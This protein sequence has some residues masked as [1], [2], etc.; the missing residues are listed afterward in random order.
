MNNWDLYK[1]SHSSDTS[2]DTRFK[3]LVERKITAVD[4]SEITVVG[5][6]A[7][8]GCG[9]LVSVNLPNA[10]SA[11]GYGIS[12]NYQLKS[13]NL[14]LLSSIGNNCFAGCPNLKVL[15]LPSLS[16]IGAS[17]FKS[18]SKLDTLILRVNTVCQLDNINAFEGTPIANGAGYIYVPSALVETYKTATNWTVYAD[19]IRAIEDYPEI[20]GG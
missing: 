1:Y 12:N 4:D 10:I 9:I 8:G 19:Q 11:Q 7:F 18:C 5:S 14:P 16:T 13:V 2:E 15:D 17:A 3:D 6:S 20:T